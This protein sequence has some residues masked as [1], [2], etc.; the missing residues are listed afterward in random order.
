MGIV[1]IALMAL[2]TSFAF[3][4][5]YCMRGLFVD[6]MDDDWAVIDRPSDQ[7]EPPRRNERI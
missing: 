3:I 7:Y 2:L 5:G 6:G 4:A 1:D